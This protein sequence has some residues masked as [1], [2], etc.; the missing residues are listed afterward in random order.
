[1]DAALCLYRPM[2][3]S[4]AGFYNS[5]LKLF[6]YLGA[7]L[8][9]VGSRLGQIAEVIEH[10]KSGLLV[11]DDVDEVAAAL[12]RLARD[13]ELAARLGA[14]GHARLQAGYTW[15]HTGDRIGAVLERL[16]GSGQNHDGHPQAA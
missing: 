12:E 5:P 9:V 1:M 11:A 7:G 16:L 15:D 6:D 13:R 14:A 8:P 2:P 10:G 3:W 4:P